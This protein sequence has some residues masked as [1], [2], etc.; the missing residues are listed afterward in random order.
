MSSNQIALTW[1][2][3]SAREAGY[4]IIRSTD[5][6]NWALIGTTP[7]NTTT[8]TDAGLATNTTYYYGIRAIDEST[9]S[10]FVY[11]SAKTVA[12]P[13]AITTA[14]T[15][16]QTV[17]TG[18][19]DSLSALGSLPGGQESDLTYFWFVAS[20]PSASF[21]PNGSNAAKNTTVTFDAPGSYFLG[22]S[23]AHADGVVKSA[24]AVTVVQTAASGTISPIDPS[25]VVS[26][27]K[28]FSTTFI[29]QFGHTM[30]MQ[31]AW[32]VADASVGTINS[33]GLFTAAGHEGSTT[34]TAQANNFTLQ[35]QVTVNTAF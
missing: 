34:V 35:T 29:D 22:V 3:N 6:L 31:V 15:A 10:D 2:D 5:N 32:S 23:I 7:A 19:T 18:T 4:Q 26:G 16:T 25:V 24:V 28:Q 1:L 13:P 33:A 9:V 17:V 12:T 14:A 30:P 8:C 27:H 21:S 11:T 20:G